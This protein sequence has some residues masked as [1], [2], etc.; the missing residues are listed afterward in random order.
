MNGLK[1]IVVLAGL[2]VV[3]YFYANAQGV[4]HPVNGVMPVKPHEF[5]PAGANCAGCHQVQSDSTNSVTPAIEGRQESPSA[6][7]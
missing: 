2:V 1:S 7:P 5:E 3:P 6:E 4:L